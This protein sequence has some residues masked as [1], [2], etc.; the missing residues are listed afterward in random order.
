MALLSKPETKTVYTVCYL[1]KEKQVKQKRR[2]G[3]LTGPVAFFL[4]ESQ[5]HLLTQNLLNRLKVTKPLPE[6]MYTHRYTKVLYTP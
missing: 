3:V 4:D 6:D 2:S 1:I 5:I